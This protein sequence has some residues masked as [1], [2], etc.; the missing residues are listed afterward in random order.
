MPIYAGGKAKIGKE[1][2]NVIQDIEQ[3]VNWSGGKYFEPFCGLLG[4]G[5][6]FAE[7]GR[8]VIACDKNKDVVLMWK[9]LKRGWTPPTSCSKT[10]YE[11]LKQSNKHSAEKGFVGIACAYSGIF[12][13]GYRV[14]NGSRNFFK[15]FR[16]GLMKMTKHLKPVTFLDSCDY[17]EF[18]PK[19]M[20][21]Y[22]DPPYKGNNFGTEH[23][24]DFNHNLFWNTMRKWSKNNLVF[25]SE[26][27]A[28][29][30]FVCVW[31]KKI[32]SSFNTNERIQR[33]EKLFM[34]R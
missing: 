14:R 11:Q 24:N 3:S 15:T 18:E 31:R 27:T 23:F 13:A 10:R 1:I 5:I 19:G 29:K 2:A 26:Y 17:T 16:T 28:P 32:K 25:V 34:L 33:T 12:F 30:D 9:A 7:D 22:C 8:K 4:V 6:H 21:I 20:T